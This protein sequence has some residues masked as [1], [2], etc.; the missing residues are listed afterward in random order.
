MQGFESFCET[1]LRT[2]LTIA[3]FKVF[4]VQKIARQKTTGHIVTVA[5]T[6]TVTIWPW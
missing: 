3:F 4:I 5:Y 6:A 2:P 1:E